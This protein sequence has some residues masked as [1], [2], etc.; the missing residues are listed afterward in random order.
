[1]ETQQPHKETWPCTFMQDRKL[2][3]TEWE[4]EPERSERV[5]GREIQR[6][7]TASFFYSLGGGREGPVTVIHFT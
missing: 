6:Q 1:M 7:S 5:G 2:E 4:R 3:K